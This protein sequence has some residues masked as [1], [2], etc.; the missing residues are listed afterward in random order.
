[1]L[2]SRFCKLTSPF[3][4]KR[5][6]EL[7]Y[8]QYI[9]QKVDNSVDWGRYPICKKVAWGVLF[10]YT[11]WE[12]ACCRIT[13]TA[14]NY[15]SSSWEVYVYQVPTNGES[16]PTLGGWGKYT[17]DHKLLF[18][19]WDSDPSPQNCPLSGK[20]TV[21]MSTQTIAYKEMDLSVY[22][23]WRLAFIISISMFTCGIVSYAYGRY[24]WGSQFHAFLK[25][26][27]RLGKFDV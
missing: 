1:M 27:W 11:K 4:Y 18:Y 10:Q 3:L 9:F 7:T 2:V 23:T 20:C 25:N 17:N 16:C 14:L 6:F 13:D 22:K 24:T 15:D 26:Q 19:K 12:H 8:V 5:S 21:H